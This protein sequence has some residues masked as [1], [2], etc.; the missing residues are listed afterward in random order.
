[1][2]RS[3]YHWLVVYSDGKTEKVYTD[4]ILDALDNASNGFEAIAV[5]KMNDHDY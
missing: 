4:N 3:F 5:F 2:G 1:M